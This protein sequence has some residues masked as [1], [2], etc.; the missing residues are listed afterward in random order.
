MAYSITR[1][2]I[3]D[4][5]AT[6]LGLPFVH[7]GRSGT[8]GVDCV[9]LLVVMGQLIGYPEI[10]DVE[11]YRRTPSANVIRETLQKN[12]DEIPLEEARVGDVF[13]MRT[14]GIKPRHAAIF[15]SD[16]TDE[17]RG[18][19]PQILHAAPKGVKLDAMGIF[20]K[21]WFVAAFRVRGVID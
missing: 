5:A 2:E 13:L 11:G 7:Q 15:F 12:M 8:A 21:S 4:A 17:E 6:M 19:R 16:Q 1:K 10:F 9:G 3:I 20:P 14:G 18:I